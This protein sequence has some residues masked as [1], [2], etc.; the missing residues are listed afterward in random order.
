MPELPELEAFKKYVIHNVLNKSI[1]DVTASYKRSIKKVTFSAF[2]KILIGK[3]FLSAK[4]KGKYLIID[5]NSSDKKIVM[6]FGLTGYLV[7]TKDKKEKVRFSKVTFIFANGSALHWCD[8]RKFGAIWLVKKLD[9]IKGL[10]KLGP[11]PLTISKKDFLILLS[12]SEKKNIKSFLMDQSIIAGIGNE[13]SDEILFQAKIN[14]HCSISDLSEKQRD[15]LY[16][17][18]NSVLKYAVSLRTKKKNVGQRYF[19]GQNNE[20]FKSTYLIPHRHGDM[21]CP[22]DKRHL[23]KKT[24]IGGRSSYYCPKDQK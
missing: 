8:I 20:G 24:K 12:Q 23:L 11:D 17:T 4:R 21:Q 6:H 2:K 7:Y 16:K 15:T 10:K 3:K 18:M 1:S 13:Y 5:L 22:K 19:S 9:E 14:P